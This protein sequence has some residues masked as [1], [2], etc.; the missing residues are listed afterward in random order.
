MISEKKQPELETIKIVNSVNSVNS[1][2]NTVH[3]KDPLI[4]NLLADVKSEFKEKDAAEELRKQ[5]E[6]E[7]EKIRQAKLKAQQKQKFKNQ[8]Q[9]WLDKLDPLSSEGLWFEKFA[10][11]YPSKLDA[12]IEYLQN[13]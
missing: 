9:K 3:Q 13:N 8:E 7:Q 2:N 1:V 11:T 6:L 12:A 10:E 5:Q 4:D